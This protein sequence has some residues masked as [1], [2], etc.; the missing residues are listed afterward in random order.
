VVAAI[1]A[2]GMNRQARAVGLLVI[3]AIFHP[4]MALA[5]WVLLLL[6]KIYD[7]HHWLVAALAALSAVLV[8]AAVGVP[9]ASG[10]LTRIDADWLAVLQARNIYLFPHLWDS[11]AYAPIVVQAASILIGTRY[12]DRHWRIIFLAALF[13]GIAGLALAFIAGKWL[14]IVLLIQ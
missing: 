6:V 4:I 11:N 3:A 14:P 8:A 1:A 2:L 5:G 13:A 7:D 10:L 12:V 9:I